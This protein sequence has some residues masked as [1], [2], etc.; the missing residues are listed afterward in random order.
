M[1]DA[2]RTI[3]LSGVLPAAVTDNSAYTNA[4]EDLYQQSQAAGEN[5]VS[6]EVDVALPEVCHCQVTGLP[7]PFATIRTLRGSDSLA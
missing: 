4:I 5:Y 2:Q 7:S 3:L 1:T 6:V